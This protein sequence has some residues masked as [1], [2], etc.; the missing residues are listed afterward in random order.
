MP[1]ASS[2]SPGATCCCS[3]ASCR[4]SRSP[5]SARLA[6]AWPG[7]SACWGG[8]RPGWRWSPATLST[9]F[10]LGELGGP[11]YLLGWIALGP[12]LALVLLTVTATVVVNG[13]RRP[14]AIAGALWSAAILVIAFLAG[15]IG[16]LRGRR[17][18]V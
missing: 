6:P 18:P 17:A 3:T 4:R 7:C 8:Q 9:A 2:R 1:A 15:L 14:G 5:W 13:G 10:G 12:L 16:Y 11:V